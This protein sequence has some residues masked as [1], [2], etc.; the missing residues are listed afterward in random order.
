M[1]ELS[2][3]LRQR[4]GAQNTAEN[5]AG[6]HPDADTLTAYSEQLL[7]TPERQRVVKHLAACV[8]CR[9]VLALSQAELPAVEMQPVLKPAPVSLWRKLLTPA[10]GVVGVIAATALIAILITQGPNR[11]NQP[12]NSAFKTPAPSDQ[13]PPAQ[14]SASGAPENRA[15]SNQADAGAAAAEAAKKDRST[16]NGSAPIAGLAALGKLSQ[17]PNRLAAP[18]KTAAPPPPVFTA[19]LRNGNGGNGN[20]GKQDFVNSAFFEAGNADLVVDGQSNKDYPSEPKPQGSVYD[21]RLSAMTPRSLSDIPQNAGNTTSTVAI[22]TPRPPQEHFG[23]RVEKTV[24]KGARTLMRSPFIA[25]AISSNSLGSRAMLASPKF[26]PQKAEQSTAVAAAPAR[27][28]TDSFAAS[29]AMSAG[30]RGS[31]NTAETT[32]ASWKVVEGKLLKAQ[33]QSPWEEARTGAPFDF[34]FVNARAGEVW[35]GGTNAGL[36]HS[37]DGG[38]TWNLVNLGEGASGSIVSILFAGNH[39]QVKT[40][41]DQSWASSDGGKSWTRN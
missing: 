32:V 9:E 13:Q 24:I 4:L 28:E 6:V 26:D 8:D 29:G 15:A 3:L 10:L 16:R 12:A 36:I 37:Y 19:E 5:G 21:S 17:L 27:A 30:A 11:P 23:S 14:P 38:N 35:A 34:T 18:A 25:P 31:L 22:L 40:S 33:G 7:P 41:D 2:N 1:S 39:V 20:G